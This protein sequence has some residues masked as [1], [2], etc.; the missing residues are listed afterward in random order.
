MT[1]KTSIII[2]IVIG[3]VS[4][5]VLGLADFN[6]SYFLEMDTGLRSPHAWQKYIISHTEKLWRTLSPIGVII[7]FLPV[8]AV[9]FL[10]DSP[11]GRIVV[12]GLVAFLLLLDIFQF[13]SFEGGD[14]KGC[15][16]CF[17]LALIHIAFGFLAI[18][19]AAIYSAWLFFASIARK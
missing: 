4:W 15:E 19:A 9:V 12:V 3:L 8:I 16:G 10:P 13:L 17:A 2:I 18:L 11:R 14:R 5:L 7:F 1:T 6:A